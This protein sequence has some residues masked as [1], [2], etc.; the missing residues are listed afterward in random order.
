MAIGTLI[1]PLV[2]GFSDAASGTAY[3]YRRG[4]DRGTPIAMYSD[5]DAT[6]T[7]GT[8]EALNSAG[9]LRAFVTE[10][11][12]IVIEDSDGE[13]VFYFET[14]HNAAM[15]GIESDSFIG[16]EDDGTQGAGGIT[17]LETAMTGLLTSFGTTNFKVIPAGQSTA[18]N[19]KTLLA[20]TAGLPFYD[21]TDAA[22]GAV[23]DGTTTDRYV[24]TTISGGLTF[25]SFWATAQASS[26]CALSSA[27][28]AY[29]WGWGT[30][31]S[32]GDGANTSRSQPVLVKLVR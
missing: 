25:S 3:A 13:E 27:G 18:S 16:T 1:A 4:T 29:C 7:L 10:E 6:E 2:S 31:G 17:T 15:V 23:G 24:P 22:Y 14:S 8:S 19:L 9:R 12:E 32:L 5:P 21:V 11:A 26:V 20:N 28:R 30:Y